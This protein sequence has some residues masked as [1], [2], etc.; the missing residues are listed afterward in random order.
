MA[1]SL[2]EGRNSVGMWRR[3]NKVKKCWYL[4]KTNV[5]ESAQS[6]TSVETEVQKGC[7]MCSVSPGGGRAQTRNHSS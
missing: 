5:I 7:E 4:I 2:F 1:C 6:F 3:P